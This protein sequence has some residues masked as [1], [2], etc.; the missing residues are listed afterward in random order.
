MSGDSITQA[1][2]GAGKKVWGKYYGD[3]QAINLGFSGDRTEHALWRLRKGRFGRGLEP[4]VSVVMIGTNNTG[5]FEAKGQ[6]DGRGSLRHSSRS[7][8]RDSRRPR[9]LLL[10]VFPRS[11]RP[12]DAPR[13]LNVEINTLIA[14]LHDGENVHYLDISSTFLEENGRISNKI[15]PDKLH[16]SEEGYALW[17][18]A[19]EAKLCEL[20]EF[21]KK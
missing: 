5:A 16:L 7:S 12:E 18:K 21:E 6:R 9:S 20:G 2:E 11:D 4:R 10:G 17:A 15:M 8:V 1:W 3:R 19:M 13:K 14:K